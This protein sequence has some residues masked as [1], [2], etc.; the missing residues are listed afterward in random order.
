MHEI[1]C[2]GALFWAEA[3]PYSLLKLIYPEFGYHFVQK[4]M[5]TLRSTATDL[6]LT[7]VGRYR[8]TVKKTNASALLPV[9]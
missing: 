1:P 8:P 2:I 6:G 4:P 3:S 7:E 5:E 9:T